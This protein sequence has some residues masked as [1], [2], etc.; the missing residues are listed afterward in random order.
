[1]E[2][3][4]T[5]NKKQGFVRVTYGNNATPENEREYKME[6]NPKSP[7]G[8]VEEWAEVFKPTETI[9]FVDGNNTFEVKGTMPELN[10]LAELDGQETWTNA[11]GDR[12]GERVCVMVEGEFCWNEGKKFKPTKKEVKELW[13]DYCYNELGSTSQIMKELEEEFGGKQ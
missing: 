10:L 1:M 3:K 5:N 12:F 13:D 2:T 6:D 11:F 9:V 8:T 4:Q 7:V